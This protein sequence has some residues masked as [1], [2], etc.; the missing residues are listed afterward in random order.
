MRMRRGASL[1]L[2]TISL[3]TLM[4]CSDDEKKPTDAGPVPTVV[5]GAGADAAALTPYVVQYRALLGADNGGDPGTRGASGFREVSWDGVPDELS[6]PN[7]YPGDFFNSPTAPRARGLVLAT[8]GTG[9]LVSADSDNPTHTPPRFGEI[10]A[11]YQTI[12]KT[13]S[14][15][16][17][18]SPVGSNIVNIHFFV[19]GTS[20]PATVRG[21]GAVYTDVDT[22]HTAFEYFDREGHSLGS[23]ETPLSNE[24]LSFLGV[25]FDQPIVY[26]VEVRY[27]T[28]ALGPADGAA[29][30]VAVMDNFIFGEPQG[31]D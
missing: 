2:T 25:A 17:L 6:A 16:R 28:S 23:Y 18:F 19:P 7:G 3:F 22:H 29:L 11:Q 4:S 15:E 20:I 8:P 30:D 1:A 24:S 27:G 26:R 10:N 14:N 12:F 5:T 31:V 9:L 21:F 13:F